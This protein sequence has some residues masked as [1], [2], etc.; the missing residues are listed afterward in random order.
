MDKQKYHQVSHSS[1]HRMNP[2]SCS[3]AKLVNRSQLLQECLRE[4]LQE[5]HEPP[6]FFVVI[7]VVSGGSGERFP[8]VKP[9]HGLCHTGRGRT[10][11]IGQ[12]SPAICHERNRGFTWDSGDKTVIQLI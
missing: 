5:P 4:N 7:V 12:E 8:C 10:H 11:A 9:I 2:S 3:M 1:Q 6:Q